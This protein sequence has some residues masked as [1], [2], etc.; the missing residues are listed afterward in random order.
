MELIHIG[1]PNVL[2]SIYKDTRFIFISTDAFAGGQGGYSEDTPMRY[3]SIKNPLAGYANAKIDGEEMVREHKNHVIIRTGPLYGQDVHG[4]WDKRTAVLVNSLSQ[5]VKV[6]RSANLYKTFVCVDD[7]RDLLLEIIESGYNGIIHAGPSQK[8]SYYSYNVKMA[9]KLG[10]DENLIIR[11]IISPE[12][13]AEEV[14]PLDTSMDTSKCR[15]VFRTNFR[16]V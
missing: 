12:R 7:L 11:D 5:N 4:S 10:L 1:L 14:I 15:A 8:E 9:E 6:S 13:A 16:D 3:Y 2:R